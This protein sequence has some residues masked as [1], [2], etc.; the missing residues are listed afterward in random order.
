M[1]YYAVV[2]RT[3]GENKGVAMIANSTSYI[4]MQGDKQGS[5]VCFDSVIELAGLLINKGMDAVI[6]VPSA[7]RFRIIKEGLYYELKN[8]RIFIFDMK[9]ADGFKKDLVQKAWD[10]LNEKYPKNNTDD[11]LEDFIKKNNLKISSL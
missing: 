6:T 3:I 5:D 9:T 4:E 10:K 2:G 8:N 7:T 1:K 11:V